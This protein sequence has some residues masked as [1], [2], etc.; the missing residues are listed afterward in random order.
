MLIINGHS[1][2]CTGRA[3][4]KAKSKPKNTTTFTFTQPFQFQQMSVRVP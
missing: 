3:D 1:C 4:H 2:P